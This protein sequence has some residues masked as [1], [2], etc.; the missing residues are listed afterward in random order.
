MATATRPLPAGDRRRITK[1]G[2][3]RALRYALRSARCPACNRSG[4]LH[5]VGGQEATCGRCGARFDARPAYRR[6]FAP[7]HRCGRW[8]A[9]VHPQELVP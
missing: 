6:V 9:T 5:V 8:V 7:S 4:G 1:A 2:Y 3:R